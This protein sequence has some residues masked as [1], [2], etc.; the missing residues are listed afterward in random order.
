MS[1]KVI[2]AMS[3]GVD[4]SVAAYL[5]I[6]EGYSCTGATMRLYEQE[7]SE[8]NSIRDAK[9]VAQRLGMDYYVF[10]FRNEFKEKVIEN[11]V[12][13]YEEGGTPNPCI[14]CNRYLKFKMMLD[15][16]EKLFADYVATGH[17]ARISCEKGWYY[18]KKAADCDKD[19]SY[20]LYSL[21]QHQL[22]HTLFPL[23]EYTKSQIRDIASEQGFLNADKKDSQD[24]CFVPDGDYAS[25][26]ESYRG[27][28]C[29][30]GDFIDKDGNVLGR[31]NGII[32][33]T[34]GQRKGLGIAF[35]KPV[36]VV[37]KLA[38]KNA[39]VLG[40]NDELF[41]RE[42]IASDFNWLIPDPDSEIKCLTKVR[43]NMKEQPAMAYKLSSEK[44]K[45]VF[46]V[47][48]RAVTKGQSAVLY[49][50]D[51]VIGGGTID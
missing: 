1:K 42:L 41:T 15:E 8:S 43:Y 17:Y 11:F 36:Y 25:F 30:S 47:P 37:D 48:Q 10:D 21:T 4:S 49:I 50:G 20:V 38:D 29:P 35:G 12:K 3:G 6:K 31:H 27:K 33:Y 5:L 7:G 19:Q 18:L 14:V 44:V 9:N 24:I 32:R 23:G 51:T 46:D 16:A 13:T 28:A 45:I 22:K 39:V 26:I 2:V 34:V 40:D